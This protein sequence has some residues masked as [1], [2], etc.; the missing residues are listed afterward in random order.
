MDASKAHRHSKS[1]FSKGGNKSLS[2]RTWGKAPAS[3]AISTDCALFISFARVVQ[4]DS[5][6]KP[7]QGLIQTTGNVR[8]IS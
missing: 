1:P 3:S 7:G 6:G 4:V 5:V 8:V 2:Q